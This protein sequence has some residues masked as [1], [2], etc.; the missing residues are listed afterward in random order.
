MSKAVVF[1]VIALGCTLGALGGH[2]RT[3]RHCEKE[4]LF[5]MCL[6]F[7]VQDGIVS[8]FAK[9]MYLCITNN[10][11]FQPCLHLVVFHR[12]VDISKHHC[13]MCL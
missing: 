13:T 11:H 6:I 1:K 2:S 5:V 9:F 12:C 8:I 4:E 3:D 10:T 7:T